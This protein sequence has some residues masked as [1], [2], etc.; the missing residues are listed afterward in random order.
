MRR[1]RVK[2]PEEFYLHAA[3]FLRQQGMA[4]PNDGTYREAVVAYPNIYQDSMVEETVRGWVTE[5]DEDGARKLLAWNGLTYEVVE[6]GPPANPLE[7]ARKGRL[8]AP[9]QTAALYSSEIAGLFQDEKL[10]GL[11]LENATSKLA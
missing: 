11:F 6:V 1:A 8:S 10:R 4:D 9:R 3:N 2:V 7:D 5:P